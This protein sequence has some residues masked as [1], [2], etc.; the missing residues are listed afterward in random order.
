MSLTDGKAAWLAV[1]VAVAWKAFLLATGGFPLNAD[2]AVVGLMARHI[3]AGSR[4]LFFYGQAYLGSLDGYLVAAA[5]R[6]I[7]ESVAAIRLVQVLLFAATVATTMALAQRVIRPGWPA[8]AAG[9]LLAVPSV[10]VTLYTTVSLGGYGE[11]ILVGNLLL[12]LGLRAGDRPG[13]LPTGVAWGALAGLGLWIFGLTI[14]YILPSGLMVAAS[15]RT[16]PR[17]RKAEAA[18]V[19]AAGLALGGAPWWYSA[20]RGG[21]VTQLGEMLGSAIAGASP[22]APLQAVT[23]HAANLALFGFTAIFGL[24]APWSTRALAPALLPLALAFWL[25]VLYHSLSPRAVRTLTGRG[26]AAL[27][28][29]VACVLAGFLLTPFGADPSGRYFLPLAVPLSL[30]AGDALDH[31]RRA[32]SPLAVAALLGG[33]LMFH[34]WG[35]L[36]S[37]LENPPGLTTQFDPS[38]WADRRHDAALIAFLSET[39]ETRGY[40]TYW[41]SYPLAFLSRESLIFAPLLPYHLDLRYTPRDDRYPPY[42]EAVAQSSRAAFITARNPAL[43]AVLRQGFDRLGLFWDEERI[44]DYTVFYGL[45]RRVDPRELGVGVSR[46]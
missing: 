35:T 45:P 30:F 18:L 15:L 23:A 4:P 9:L 3:L 25:F 40:T 38:T 11:A 22:G 41:V 20:L 39:G 26:R 46:P 17:R 5:F 36:Q 44:G 37:A 33:V 27:F 7:G 10:N 13:D 16:A 14:V 28:G 42:R 29:V 43:E 21:L 1:G 8:L 34:A 32:V 24:R 2:E 31:I 12:L 6:A 19:I